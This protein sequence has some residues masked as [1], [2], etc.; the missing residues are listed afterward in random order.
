MTRLVESS[1]NTNGGDVKN[2]QGSWLSNMALSDSGLLLH[3]VG[4][5]PATELVARAACAADMG[6]RNRM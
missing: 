3:S 1:A 5:L 2:R 6:T 4:L